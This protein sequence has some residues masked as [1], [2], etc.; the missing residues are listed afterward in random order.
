MASTRFPQGL[1]ESGHSQ[2]RDGVLVS[3]TQNW[4]GFRT[5]SMNRKWQKV[6]NSHKRQYGLQ[7]A[8]SLSLR[9][10][11]KPKNHVERKLKL[12]H[13]EKHWG[14]QLLA[15]INCKTG[16]WWRHVRWLQ[17]PGF[18]SS[19]WSSRHHGAEISHPMCPAWIPDLQNLWAKEWLFDVT[20]F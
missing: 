17:S 15:W 13:V 9:I 8:S 16:K 12:A 1:I 10:P 3:S 2:P 7:L 19:S 11:L 14:S 18:E 4:V 5:A 6:T 20:K